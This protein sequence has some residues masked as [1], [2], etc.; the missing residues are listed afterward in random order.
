MR[1]SLGYFL[2]LPILGLTALVAQDKTPPAKVVLPAKNGN[3]TFD[4]AAHA[5]RENNKCAACHPALYAQDQKTP[6]AFKPPHKK[7]ENNKA[8]CG[9][10]HRAEGTAFASSGNC[11]NGKCHVRGS[12]KE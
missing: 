9:S 11:T 10:C 3:V 12:A 2:F 4:H 7:D 6:V 5:K 8:S 1:K